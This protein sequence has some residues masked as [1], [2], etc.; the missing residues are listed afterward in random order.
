MSFHQVEKRQNQQKKQKTIENTVVWRE[1]YD[2]FPYHI[3]CYNFKETFGHLCSNEI[4][5][6]KTTLAI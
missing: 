4:R 1:T 5:Q 2:V 3:I 6:L